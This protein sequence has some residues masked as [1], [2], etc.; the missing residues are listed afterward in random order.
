MEQFI[1]NKDY[2]ERDK[3][4]FGN[5]PVEYL[6]GCARFDELSVDKLQ[7]LIDNKF[8]CL[9]DAQ[10]NS[11]TIR[12]FL[13]FGNKYP[14]TTF[15]GYVISHDRDDY[16][17]TIEGL[18]LK[19]NITPKTLTDFSNLFYEADDFIVDSNGVLYCWYD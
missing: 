6:G 16:R 3:I 5:N 17:V 1:F 15:H 18:T 4:I 19:S 8:A 9:D 12:E 14:D 13:K 2:L 7:K 11:P 10:N